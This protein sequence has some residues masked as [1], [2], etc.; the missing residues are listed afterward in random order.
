MSQADEGAERGRLDENARRVQNW[1]RW[2]PYLAD[3]QWGTVR[4]DYSPT[5]ECW[6]YF[7]H[8]MS[9]SRVYRWGE[10]GLLGLCDRECR[11]CIA[12]ALWNGRDPILKERLFGLTGPEGNH[13]EDCKELYYFLDATPTCS[14]LKALYKYPQVEYPYGWLVD[15]SRRRGKA[16]PEFEIDDTGIFDKGYWDVVVEYAKDSPDDVLIRYTVVN[17]GTSAQSIHVLPQLWLR[18]TWS[19]G[20]H[21]EGYDKAGTIE[22]VGMS[23]AR[24]AHPTLGNYRYEVDGHLQEFLFTD[25]ETNM[26]RLYGAPSASKYTKD[27]FH[28]RVINGEERAVNH[29]GGGTKCAA[30]YLLEVPPGGSKTVRARLTLESQVRGPMF[31]EFDDIFEDRIEEADEYHRTS[32]NAPMSDEERKVVRQADAGLVWTRKFYHY[33]VEHWLDG[34]PAQPAPPQSRR[35]GRN[36]AWDQLWARDV[37]SMPDGWEYPWFAAWDLAFHCVAMARFDPEFAKQQLLLLC[38]E[39]YMHPNGQ[40]PA[41]E[42]AFGDVNPP[43]HAWAVWRVY[44]LAAESGH[45]HDRV[46]LERAF[47][48][49]LV[50][51]TWWVN[52]EDPTG[53]NLFTGGFLGL[54]NVGVFDRSQPMPG[55]GKLLQADA[56]AWMAFYCTTMISMGLELAKEEPPYADLALKFFEHFVQIAKAMNNLGGFGLWSDDDGFYYDQLHAHGNA[57]SLKIRS[58][59]GLVPLF[60]ATSLDDEQLSKSSVFLRRLNW[61][62]E[63]RPELSRTI[64]VQ[65][66]ANHQHRLLAIPNRERLQRVLRYMLDET[67]FLSPYGVRSLSRVHL[68]RP[69]DIELDG[70]HYGVHY[71][72]GESDSGMF[73]GNSNWRGPVWFPVN[74]LLVE[75]L[76]R[77][78]HFYGETFQIDCPT[79]SGVKM[80]LNGVAAELERRLCRLFLADEHGRR[81]THGMDRR[82]IEDPAFKDL[83]LF[84]EYFHGDHGRGLGASH[85]TGWTALAANMMERQAL[86]RTWR[87]RPRHHKH[88]NGGPAAFPT[89]ERP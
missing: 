60:A 75:A 1:Q 18:N 27:A 76:K 81:P 86:Y 37:I 34:D 54:D 63:N 68:K 58:M 70:Q 82:Y 69:Y 20:R 16:D 88:P 74:Y 24:V 4:E 61:F 71:N 42:F 7:S 50:N 49:L 44:Q 66:D 48:K 47:D 59:V 21:G 3:R 52:R 36:K 80:N 46:F 65:L 64:S 39:W 56:T 6:E 30:W 57:T 35:S 29:A 77:Y 72:P 85:Q 31:D 87:E 10:D 73:G 13:G 5:G 33:I 89:V 84:Y 11:I 12:P 9:R 25:N 43:V 8:D 62:I 23:A 15:E 51:F 32:R 45:G 55:G 53:D 79:G 2:G 78:H 67:E 22:R 26:E 19:W 14:Y 83:V 38:R 41:Y 17:R 40:F 28:R